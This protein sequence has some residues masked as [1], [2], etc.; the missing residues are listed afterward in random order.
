MQQLIATTLLIVTFSWVPATT[1]TVVA[2]LTS[3]DPISTESSTP[4]SRPALLTDEQS[5]IIEWAKGRF[6]SAGL[7]LP[8]VNFIVHDSI[9]MCDGHVGY[10]WAETNTLELC[11]LD[12]KTLLHELAHAWANQNLTNEQRETFIELRGLDSWNDQQT[13][14]EDRATEHAAETI[15]WALLDHDATVRWVDQTGTE[16]RTLLTIGN[17]SPTALAEAYGTL[18]GRQ[19]PFGNQTT[20]TT[21]DYSPEQRR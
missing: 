6:E 1:L 11:R 20:G 19:P 3:E 21:T 2:P 4:A 10:Y 5:E 17:S 8:D 12:E 18:T 15:M 9:S 13:E 7:V 16:T 14:W